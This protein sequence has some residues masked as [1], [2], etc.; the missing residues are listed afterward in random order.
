VRFFLDFGYQ[1]EHVHLI[2]LFPQ[3]FHLESVIQL[4]HPH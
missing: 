1:V 2:D 4:V 3:S